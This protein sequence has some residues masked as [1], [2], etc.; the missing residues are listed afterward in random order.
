MK[1]K[2]IAMWVM[3]LFASIIMLQTLWFKFSAHPESVELFSKLGTEPW[4]R[5]GTGVLELI[6]SVL[7]LIPRFSVYGAIMGVVIMLGAILCHLIIIGIE[8]HG[9]GGQ[10]FVLAIVVMVCSAGNLFLD[11]DNVNELKERLFKEGSVGL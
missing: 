8:S 3:R 4:G 1:V 2:V 10:L 7:L 6:A 9:D 5:I 11:T